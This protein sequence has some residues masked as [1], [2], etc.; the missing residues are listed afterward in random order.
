LIAT[1]VKIEFL[2]KGHETLWDEYVLRNRQGTLYHLSGWRRAI[3][4]AYGH[5]SYSLVAL[6]ASTD[7]SGKRRREIVGGLPLIHLRPFLFGNVLISLPFCDFAG[8]IAD[9]GT[10][11]TELLRRALQLARE[12]RCRVV[13][14]RHLSPHI[15][16]SEGEDPCGEGPARI[17][18][19]QHKV[20]MLREVA[21]SAE[22]LMRSFKA[23]LRSQIRR[24]VKDGLYA[25]VG[26]IELL[27]DFYDVF[28]RNMRDL[29]SPVHSKQFIKAVS[30]ELSER[31]KFVIVYHGRKP[32]ACSMMIGCGDTLENPWASALHQ[33]SRMSPNMLL[34]WKMLEYACD[35]GYAYFDFGRS[36]QGEGTYRFKEQWG[37]RPSP[38]Y[39]SYILTGRFSVP[40]EVEGKGRQIATACWR[41]LPVPITRFMGPPIRKHIG[42]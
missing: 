27:D 11:E 26:E 31:S 34:Y 22:D 15:A 20:R 13:E 2:E 19:R 9:N 7:P 29:G 33:Y 35:N 5:R 28:A 24:P 40:G 1:P 25:V 4:K 14:L 10:I 42:L 17:V 23:K 39:W 37:A 36:S 12:L 21:A 41:R 18:T 32:L 3:E 38:L 30:E 8:I 16:L 6:R